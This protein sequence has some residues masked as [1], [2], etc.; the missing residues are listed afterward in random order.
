MFE[1]SGAGSLPHPSLVFSE[2]LTVE[3]ISIISQSNEFCCEAPQVSLLETLG[4]RAGK[5]KRS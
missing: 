5:V 3:A 1:T 2:A 4:G